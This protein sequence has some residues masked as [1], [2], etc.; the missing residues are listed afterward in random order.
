MPS[1]VK[2]LVERADGRLVFLGGSTANEHEVWHLFSRVIYLAID[3]QTLRDRLA[4]RTSN[5][6]G[7]SP[8]ELGAILSWHKVGEADYLRFGA[9]VINATLP[10]REVVDNILEAAA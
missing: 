9:V 3:E 2:A 6:F 4:S 1:K 8:K 5:D 10:L 7:K